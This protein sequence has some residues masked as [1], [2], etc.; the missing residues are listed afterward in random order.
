MKD[1][2]DVQETLSLLFNRDDVP[3]KMLMY[4]SK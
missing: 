4:E 1:K 2:G 3:S